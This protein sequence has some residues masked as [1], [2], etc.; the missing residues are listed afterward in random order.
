[1]KT[2]TGMLLAG[3]LV[4][5]LAACG[6]S[7]AETDPA[8]STETVQQDAEGAGKET[9]T[10]DQ[11]QCAEGEAQT[12]ENLLFAEDVTV[13][14]DRGQITFVN[15]DFQGNV[16]L[17]ANEGTQVVLEGSTVAGQCIFRNE[18]KEA[19]MAW[20]FPKFL[21]DTKVKVVCE[22]CVGAVLP[23]GDLELVFDGQTYTMADAALFVDLSNPEAG[24]VPCTGQEASYFCVA[25]WWEDGT[26]NVLVECE[27]DPNM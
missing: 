17:T 2:I 26:K 13:S 21:V 15:C 10:S 25:Q 20:S 8:E 9:A 19:T 12:V 11:F 6:S 1:M 23:M 7:P 14:G 5:S 27:Y 22:D 18:T 16:V 24:F 3:L 4:F